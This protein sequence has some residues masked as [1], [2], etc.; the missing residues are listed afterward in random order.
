MPRGAKKGFCPIELA[1]GY[2]FHIPHPST[3]PLINEGATSDTSD[4]TP[5]PIETPQ[6]SNSKKGSE[7]PEQPK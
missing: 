2:G 1:M 3:K 6:E 5:Q 7:G 4:A